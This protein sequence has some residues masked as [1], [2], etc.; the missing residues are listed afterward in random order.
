[1]LQH[2]ADK[3]GRL[4]TPS[5]MYAL[6]KHT[7][8]SVLNSVSRAQFRRTV[9]WA[10][11]RSSFYREAFAQRGI[12]AADVRTPADL[13]DFFTTPE[14]VAHRA[15]EFICRPANIVFESSGTTG[16]N[17]R[18]YY[19][20]DELEG[21]GSV[22]A[23]GMRLM[24]VR[25]HDRI[26]NGFDFSIWIP[27]MLCHYGL[28]AAGNFCLAFGKV[29]PVEV[30]R[31]LNQY[32]FTVVIGEP[33]WLI[34]LTELA[35]RDG[36]GT[37]RMLIG[38]AE[39]MPADAIPWM[40]KVWN[41]ASIR[42]CYGSVEQGSALGFQP[43]RNFD[44]YHVD[45]SSFMPEIVDPDENGYG[46]LV[47]TTLFRRTMPLIRY[48]TRDVTRFIPGPC[49]CGSGSPRI[50][51]LRGRRDELV[52]ASGGNLYPL[53][54]EGILGPIAG[55]THDFQIVFRLA[56]VREIMEIHVE[57]TRSDPETLMSEIKASATQQYPDLMKNLALGIFE[58]RLVMHAPETIRG[59]RKIKRMIDLRYATENPV[60][61]V[62]VPG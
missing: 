55:L 57:T 13:G 42:M 51:K 4:L 41:G 6:Y 53:M 37:L 9:T 40:E 22:E 8:R 1:M 17:K 38:G 30:Y 2:I 36:G 28:M 45:D 15:E 60:E 29:D 49:P 20:K 61:A 47:F 5:T 43:C 44:G 11:Q 62:P 19:T 14:D 16:K 56:G 35:E 25:P 54:F 52:V 58:M 7:P 48:R 46:E 23:V 59:G 39:E 33:T 10:G 34:R 50:E 18:I 32:N 3:F 26:A 12:R 24:G 21:M 31:R 27:G